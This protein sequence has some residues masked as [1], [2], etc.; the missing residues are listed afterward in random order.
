MHILN[1]PAGKKNMYLNLICVHFHEN[2][3]VCKHARTFMAMIKFSYN[4]YTRVNAC[5]KRN[6]IYK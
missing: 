2:C 1:L 4:I 5:I 6:I 3:T